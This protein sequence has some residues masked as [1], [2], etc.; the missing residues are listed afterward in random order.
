MSNLMRTR[1]ISWAAV[2]LSGVQMEAI[3]RAQTFEA[4]KAEVAPE[5][6]AAPESPPRYNIPWGSGGF[7]FNAG[8]RGVYVDNVF[9]T[10]TGARDDFILMPELNV[11]AFFPVGLSN[12]V[13]LNLGVAYYLYFE[14]PSLN[15]PL[16][17]PDSVLAFNIRGG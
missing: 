6:E 7:N 3:C 12:T 15:N 17:N 8:L 4:Q 10:Q 5:T 11:A 13:V 1:L 14:N 16:I 9:L 2:L